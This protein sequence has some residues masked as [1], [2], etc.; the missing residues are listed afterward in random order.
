MDTITPSTISFFSPCIIMVL[1]IVIMITIVVFT[2]I[3]Y[4]NNKLTEH[5]EEENNAL[6]DFT[7]QS[8]KELLNNIAQL[9]EDSNNRPL[10]KAEKYK[11]H[12]EELLNT[13]QKL[14]YVIKDDLTTTMNNTG[15]CR[16]ALYLLHNGQKSASGINFLKVSC[17]GERILIGSGV[18]EQ[19]INH[20]NIPLNI[21]DNMLEKLIENGR[22]IV[23]NDDATMATARAQFIS[24]PKVRYTQEVSIY[25]SS[26]NILGFVLA[27]YDHVYNKSTSDEEYEKLKEFSNKI[28]PILTFSNYTNLTLKDE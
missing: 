21:F 23:M 15:A 11:Q 16:V 4:S 12:H 18:K 2:Y 20:S 13:F 24:A 27:E 6:K 1:F 17:V 25:D 19:I 5:F 8:N 3:R 28:S 14:R 10:D 22:Y 26:N 9:L 7:T